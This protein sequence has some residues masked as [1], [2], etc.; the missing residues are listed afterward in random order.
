LYLTVKIS[1]K[2]ISALIDCGST[3]TYLSA[4]LATLLDLEVEDKPKRSVTLPNGDV[5]IS[6]RAV[7]AGVI[8]GGCRGTI[9]FRLLDMAPGIILG[10][11]WMQSVGATIDFGTGV[12]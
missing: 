11:D 12:I 2:E 7:A 10:H 8:I 1:G 3:G 6:D 9:R 5:M 4:E